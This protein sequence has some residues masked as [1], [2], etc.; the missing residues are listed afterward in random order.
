ML[1]KSCEY[2]LKAMIYVAKNSKNSKNGRVGTKEI[3]NG[4]EAP[5]NFI[6]KIMQELSKRKLIHSAKGPN[7]GF[8]LTEDDMRRSLSDVIRAIDGDGLFINCVLGLK[9]CS[10]KNPCPVH[11]QYKEVKQKLIGI[12]E[13]N[14]IGQFNEKLETGIYFLKND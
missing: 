11:H 1:S 2:A 12:F 8:F 13:N 6:A 14:T 4:I 10:E 3:A 5:E 9:I 7:G